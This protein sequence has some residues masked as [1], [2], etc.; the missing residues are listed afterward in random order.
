MIQQFVNDIVQMNLKTPFSRKEAL[1]EEI[2][3]TLRIFYDYCLEHN[4]PLHKELKYMVD[5]NKRPPLT[6][7]G[8]SSHAF[9]WEK[10]TWPSVYSA[11]SWV[12][13]ARFF[14]QP[15]QFKIGSYYELIEF[16]VISL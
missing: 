14:I 15:H 8:K 4:N 16:L 6:F 9:L 7:L 2:T 11:Y 13:P 10:L 12:L 5:N 3:N 1:V